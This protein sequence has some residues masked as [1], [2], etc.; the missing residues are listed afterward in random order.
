MW[1]RCC[2]APPPPPPP[3]PPPETTA[4]VADEKWRPVQARAYLQSLPILRWAKLGI[5]GCVQRPSRAAATNKPEIKPDELISVPGATSAERHR[6]LVSKK[7][8]RAAAAKSLRAHLEWRRTSLPVP[9]ERA[10]VPEWIYQYGTARDGTPVIMCHP[11]RYSVEVLSAPP[12]APAH[13]PGS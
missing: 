3:P 10:P 1:L 4:S 5:N 2:Q 6:Y 12:P 13:A 7:G 11:Q 8:D 9:E